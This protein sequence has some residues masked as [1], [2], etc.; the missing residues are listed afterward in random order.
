VKVIPSEAPP[1]QVATQAAAGRRWSPRRPSVRG[2][3]PGGWS[4]RQW[5]L[6]VV[7]AL[8]AG[9]RIA[10]FT[11]GGRF[12][13]RSI[14]YQYQ[15]LDLLQLKVHTVHSILY[16]HT[17]PPLFNSLVSLIYWSPFST[18]VGFKIVYLLCGVVMAWALY[19]LIVDLG[20]RPVIAVVA[21]AL[22]VLNP[23]L[24][25][26]ESAPTY[27]Y[28]VATLLVLA[29]RFCLK[30]AR[31]RRTRDFAA[32]V[33]VITAIVM[34]RS[35]FHPIWLLA[36]AALALLFAR[37]Q[38]GWKP[39]AAVMLIPVLL[40]GGWMV[41]NQ[42]LFGTPTMSSW[43]G[44]NLTRAV[45]APLPRPSFDEMRANHELSR[46]AAVPAFPNFGPYEQYAPYVKPCRSHS[47]VRVIRDLVKGNRWSNYNA[48]CFL[49]VYKA[50]YNDAV[51]AMKTYP[52][53]YLR[54]RKGPLLIY[55]GAGEPYP[56]ARSAYADS[57]HAVED[58]LFL[59]T[60]VKVSTRNWTSPLFGGTSV[61]FN[62]FIVLGLMIGL[63]VAAGI[64]SGARR[65]RRRGDPRDLAY[66]F[67]G[68][69]V[70]YV[71]IV[72]AAFELGE[73]ARFRVM[74]DPIVIAPATAIVVAGAVR[75]VT[76]LRH[77]RS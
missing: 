21:T 51:R 55:L 33:V 13:P 22:V 74:I 73:N 70:L 38:A 27:E 14:N 46:L 2:W 61:R 6:A 18:D 23:V 30:Y 29:A 37:P 10:Y 77:R 25:R 71:T 41:K 53:D 42:I 68:F 62:I 17:Q 12:V 35:L 3:S 47:K 7:L 20:F 40:V 49:P 44:M 69:T 54:A 45:I 48:E 66:V 1:Q 64:R 39:I 5:G 36:V 8:Y 50:Q 15:I 76:A 19:S 67:I 32:L 75:G 72:S 63:V 65:L 9:S 28:P 52:L 57:M 56:T 24:V 11:T 60:S 34:T 43:F 4:A 26:Y 59:K 58:A 16:L 31:T